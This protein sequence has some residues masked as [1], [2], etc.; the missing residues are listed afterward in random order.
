MGRVEQEFNH[1]LSERR[2]ASVNGL[3]VPNL[4]KHSS[5]VILG[6]QSEPNHTSIIKTIERKDEG[7]IIL[8]TNMILPI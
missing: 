5:I 2:Q 8:C 6:Q 7:D 4:D 3:R 1:K